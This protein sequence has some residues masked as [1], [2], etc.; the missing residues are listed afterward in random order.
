MFFYCLGPFQQ[1]GC[2]IRWG[3]VRAWSNM[4]SVI[5]IIFH[6]VWLF[7]YLFI[8]LFAAMVS[9]SK[10]ARIVMI[11][12]DIIVREGWR[13]VFIFNSCCVCWR[14]NICT[15]GEGN[16]REQVGK[17][18]IMGIWHVW[19]G[20][21]RPSAL[22]FWLGRI[23]FYNLNVDSRNLTVQAFLVSSHWPPFGSPLP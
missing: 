21:G 10:E 23:C 18:W 1:V 15:W 20:F 4:G 12:F 13:E 22:Y 5:P 17:E 7:I 8:F 14:K 16:G 19:P 9:C 6:F 2:W 3:G 11:E